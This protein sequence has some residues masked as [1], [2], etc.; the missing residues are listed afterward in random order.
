MSQTLRLHSDLWD[1]GTGED[2]TASD[3]RVLGSADRCLFLR[4]YI[5][6]EY[7]ILNLLKVNLCS[8]YFV[9]VECTC[10]PERTII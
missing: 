3:L 9:P 7:T 4:N 6:G 10:L 5:L 2:A 8:M 1:F